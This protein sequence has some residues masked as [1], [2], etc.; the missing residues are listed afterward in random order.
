MRGLTRVMIILISNF[1]RCSGGRWSFPSCQI[2]T[3]HDTK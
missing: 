1:S 3:L 2:V